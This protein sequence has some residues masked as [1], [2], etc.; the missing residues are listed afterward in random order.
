MI[1]LALLACIPC[2]SYSVYLW[3]EKKRGAAIGN[4][5]PGIGGL[6]L[7]AALFIIL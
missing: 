5:I 2:A 6:A 7:A 4:M 1:I 3:K